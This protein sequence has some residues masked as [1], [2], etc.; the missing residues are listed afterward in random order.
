[1]KKVVIV[2]AGI[3]GLYFANL[4]SRHT[5]YKILICEKHNSINVSEGYGIQLSVNSVELLNKIGFDNIDQLNKFNP[6]NIDFYSLQKKQ[7]ICDLN[8]SKFNSNNSKY[9]TIRRSTLI[10]FLKEKLPSNIIEYSKKIKK[11]ND[12]KKVVE[13]TFEND[14]SLEC[15]YLIICD[16]VFSSTKTLVVK[17]NF[18]PIYSNS[19]A[20]RGT[21]N[22]KNLENINYKNI[23]LFLGS[24]L[25]SVIYPID[26]SDEFNFITILEKNLIK[27]KLQIYSLTNDS[28]FVSSVLRGLSNQI[29]QKII[30][31]INDIKCFPIFISNKI[32]EPRHK[33]IFLIGDAFFSFP[34]SF[35][36]GASQ[37]IETAFELYN[38]I[39]K[40]NN[41]FNSKRIKRTKMINRRSKFN[42]FSFHFSNPFM[43]FL[44]NL[45]MKY[46]IKNKTFINNYLGKVYKN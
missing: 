30:K 2:G 41:D 25:H 37:A 6:H 21:I 29:D 10:N 3:S 43:I 15:D 35:A 12:E 24:N 36:Q 33:N 31:N 11:I 38:S 46:L 45:F 44:R 18:N 17:K 26:K 8:I 5:D 34:P 14:S 20:I 9:T 42:N 39:S 28:N 16:G 22:K 13:L 23:S 4:L 40:N 32:Q 1:M 7:K 19:I 27:D